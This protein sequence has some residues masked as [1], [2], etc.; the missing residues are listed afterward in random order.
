MSSIE[1]KTALDV[2]MYKRQRAEAKAREGATLSHQDITDLTPEKIQQLLH[3]LGVHQIELEM[4]NEE[5]RESQLALETAHTRFFDLYDLAPVG[6]IAMSEHSIIAQANL[7]AA[8]LFDVAR[9]NLLKQALPQRVVEVDQAIYYRHRKQLI[10]HGET[11]VFELRMLRNEGVQFWAQLT[12]TIGQTA[13]DDLELRVVLIDISERKSADAELMHLQQDLQARN[14]ELDHARV[15]AEIANQAKSD[16]LSSMSH[17]LRTPLHAILGFG[18]LLEYS[19][20]PPAPE[21]QQNI[22]QILKAGWHLMALINEIL[23][24]TVIEAGKTVLVME[25]IAI[26]ELFLECESM[27]QTMAQEHDIRLEFPVAEPYLIYS[28]RLRLKQVLINLLSNAVK[29]NRPGG[30]ITV[31]CVMQSAKRLRIQVTDTGAGLT[32]DQL[33]QLFQAFNRL[34]QETKAEQGTGIGLFVSK[35]LLELMG[36]A[37][38]VESV[39]GSGSVFWIEL[40]LAATPGNS[41]IPN[42]SAIAN[43]MSAQIQTETPEQAAAQTHSLLY[44]ED[45]PGNR[46]LVEAI[47]ARRPHIRLLS[48][49]NGKKGI[50]MAQ[51][52]QPGLILMD[53]DL[54]DISGIDAMKALAAD[55]LT[56]RIPVVALSANAMS[57]DI[58]KGL[59]AGFLRYLTKPI[60]ISAFMEML[61]TELSI[62]EA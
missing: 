30:K 53:I 40:D 18:Q 34:G 31:D 52:F 60:N 14:S 29:Y 41:A 54:P 48:A 13:A 56:A 55:P 23:D 3:E 35:R 37:I 46:L 45:N 57:H 10:E 25:P 4:Q 44:V 58:E 51:K 43:E 1:P 36:G 61:D 8:S 11:Q 7:T 2:A 28:D 16:F 20:P 19:T 21:Q 33:Q 62:R 12:M 22:Q 47:I 39:I 24:L 15:I 42:I 27:I 49:P 38:G 5:L 50:E 59:K 9:G 26:S 17:E 6:Y 32:Q